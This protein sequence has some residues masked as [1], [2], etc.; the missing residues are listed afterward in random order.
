MAFVPQ[1]IGSYQATCSVCFAALLTV[2][3]HEEVSGFAFAMW[4]VTRLLRYMQSYGWRLFVTYLDINQKGLILNDFCYTVCL[5]DLLYC[6]S[7]CIAI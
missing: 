3:V 2:K 7:L 6:C 5:Y 4:Q 1:F